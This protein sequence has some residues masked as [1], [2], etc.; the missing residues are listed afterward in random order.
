MIVKGIEEDDCVG[1]DLGDAAA[2]CNV[3][4]AVIML[5]ML[6]VF[7]VMMVCMMVA[8]YRECQRAPLSDADDE[9]IHSFLGLMSLLPETPS[10]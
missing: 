4:L 9:S 6:M 2:C 7:K 1:D 5:V 10:G 3:F 8:S